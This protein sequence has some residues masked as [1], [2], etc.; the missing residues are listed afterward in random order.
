M[1]KYSSW[2]RCRSRRRSCRYR[3]Y[4]PKTFVASSIVCASVCVCLCAFDCFYVFLRIHLA[5]AELWMENA[6][7]WNSA[8]SYLSLAGVCVFVCLMWGSNANS[9]CSQVIENE[10]NKSLSFSRAHTNTQTYYIERHRSI[11][12]SLLPPNTLLNTFSETKTHTHTYL[13]PKKT[14]L[15]QPGAKS[16]AGWTVTSNAQDKKRKESEMKE[17]RRKYRTHHKHILGP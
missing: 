4:R 9:K 5:V 10:T 15:K 11:P 3:S 12:H 8:K 14:Q 1:G 16:S 6:K 7:T 17:R 2:R 13:P